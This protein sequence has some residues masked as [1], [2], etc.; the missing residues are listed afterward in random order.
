MFMNDY[1][2]TPS[3]R[4]QFLI[5]INDM[6]QRMGPWY[7]VLARR[8]IPVLL[9]IIPLNVVIE[10]ILLYINRHYPNDFINGTVLLTAWILSILVFVALAILAPKAASVVEFVVGFAYLFLALRYHLF[11]NILGYSLL[12]AM[13]LF[14]VV[15]VVFLVFKIMRLKEFSGDK[16]KHIERDESGR[17]VRNVNEEIVFSKEQKPDKDASPATDDEFY[18]VKE[19]KPTKENEPVV[20]SDD[21]FFFVK[22]DK[23]KDDENVVSDSDNDFFFG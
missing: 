20:A 12:I 11:T 7:S 6:Q 10:Q 19:D 5:K 8:I 22:N 4:E 2:T 23:A 3:E 1:D 14:L 9:F 15:K 13:I 21:D 17:I 16:A 18:F